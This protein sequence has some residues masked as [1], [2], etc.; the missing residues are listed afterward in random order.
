MLQRI[1][2]LTLTEP[3]IISLIWSSYFIKSCNVGPG[4]LNWT[5]TVKQWRWLP[6]VNVWEAPWNCL[7]FSYPSVVNFFYAEKSLKPIYLNAHFQHD[8]VFIIEAFPTSSSF[9][10]LFFTHLLVQL[11]QKLTTTTTMEKREGKRNEIF[12]LKCVM[13]T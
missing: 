12:K 11:H 13:L 7:C 6:R 8:I 10:R 1:A 4:R 5:L 2:S 9:E 3:Q